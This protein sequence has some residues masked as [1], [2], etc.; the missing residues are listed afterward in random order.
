MNCSHDG[1]SI[2]AMRDTH[3]ILQIV[4]Y[5]LLTFS[6]MEASINAIVST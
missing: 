4:E 6:P 2:S 5:I 3:S 1:P